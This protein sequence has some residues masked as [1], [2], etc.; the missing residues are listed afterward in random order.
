MDLSVDEI[1][2]LA[3]Q[4]RRMDSG[5]Q[6]FVLWRGQRAAVD[7]LV[8]EEL[9]LENGQT[10]NDAIWR[11]MLQAQLAQVRAAIQMREATT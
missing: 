5:E 9:G 4:E 7:P 1:R 8:A 10:I 11:A 3:D 2:M 6:R